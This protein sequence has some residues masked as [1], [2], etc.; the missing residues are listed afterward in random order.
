MENRPKPSK[1]CSLNQFDCT[2][3]G[4]VQ[5]PN[6]YQPFSSHQTRGVFVV[7][8][9]ISDQMP[10]IYF[11]NS[12]AE[13]IHLQLFIEKIFLLDTYHHM[14]SDCSNSYHL[15]AQREFPHNSFASNSLNLLITSTFIIGTRGNS[16][17]AQESRNSFA[18]LI[19]RL[20]FCLWSNRDSENH[21]AP[22]KNMV[23][24]KHRRTMGHRQEKFDKGLRHIKMLSNH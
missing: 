11:N 7:Y 10:R 19:L 18:L 8:K 12:N 2:S 9:I 22:L 3:K 24:E 21:F 5:K 16:F 15:L 20:S 17:L 4:N 23:D 14:N 1:H 6:F 13:P